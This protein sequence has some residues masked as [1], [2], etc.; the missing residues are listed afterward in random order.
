VPLCARL[1]LNE[2]GISQQ[3]LSKGVVFTQLEVRCPTIQIVKKK[4]VKDG[5]VFIVRRYM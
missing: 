4:D 5:N 2:S 1:N 3:Y